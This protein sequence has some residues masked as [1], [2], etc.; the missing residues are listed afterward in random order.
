MENLIVN[1]ARSLFN[2]EVVQ[3]MANRFGE[4]SDHLRKGLEGVI[5]T[6]LLALQ[7]QDR[8]DLQP[9]LD[10]AKLTYGT[11]NATSR[12]NVETPAE[13]QL[14]NSAATQQSLMLQ[15]FGGNFIT[16]VEAVQMYAGV[17]SEAAKGLIYASVPAIF[18]V[19][20]RNGV[21]WSTQHIYAT[22]QD[23]RAGIVEMLPSALST[24]TV[25]TKMDEGRRAAV[26][27]VTPADAIVDPTH[28]SPPQ[29]VHNA[30]LKHTIQKPN[31]VRRSNIWWLIAFAIILVLWFMFGRGCQGS[32][33][34]TADQDTTAV[35]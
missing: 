20:S 33:S 5:P 27:P 34:S 11:L 8:D 29:T 21:D 14:D 22:L 18:S 2:Q 1:A 9:I 23:N 32:S 3:R 31:K 30:P 6:V 12:F 10:Q 4:S 19:L 17:K 16:V 28:T 35:Y 13:E 15:L 24:L 7:R 26:P 25:N